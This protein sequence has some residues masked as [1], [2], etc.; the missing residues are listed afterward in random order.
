MVMLQ[1]KDQCILL[2][3]SNSIKAVRLKCVILIKQSSIRV[4]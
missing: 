2:E 4:G 1:L 3:Q